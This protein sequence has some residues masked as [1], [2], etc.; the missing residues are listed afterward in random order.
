MRTTLNHDNVAAARPDR[1]RRR[2][3]RCRASHSA[4]IVSLPPSVPSVF[5]SGDPDDVRDVCE[6]LEALERAA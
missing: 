6:A 5:G 1:T 3:G 4:V 2:Q